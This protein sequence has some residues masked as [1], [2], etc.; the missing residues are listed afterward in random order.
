MDIIVERYFKTFIEEQRLTGGLNTANFEK[1]T[2]YI[3]LASKNIQNFDLLSS[4]VGDGSDAGIDGIAIAINNRYVNNSAE[5]E[6]ILNNHM[7]YCVELF[8][9]QA[10]TSESFSTKEIGIFGDGVADVLRPE[11]EIKKVM[12]DSVQEKYKM[13]QLI[14]D[15][16]MY[17]KKM[18]LSL[19]YV[20]PGVYKEDDNL[21]SVQNRVLETI[22]GLDIVDKEDI[23]LWLLDKTF[24]RKQFE[25]TKIQNTATFELQNKIDIPY[26]NGVE[27]AFLAIM[28]VKEYLKIIVDENQRIRRGI[29]ELNVRDFA[30]SD[31]NRVNQDIIDTL[32]SDNR[33]SFG[34]LNNGIT[35][36][37]RSLSKGMGKYTIKN[38]YIV[39]G[40][41]TSN[42]LFENSNSLTDDM[43]VSLKIVI[44]QDDSLIDKIVKATNNQTEVQE[45]QLISMDEYQ[46]EL[47]SY[48]YSFDKYTKLYYERRDGQYRNRQDISV[49]QIVNP[50]AQMKSFA[51]VFLDLPHIASRFS[52]K[53]QDEVSKKIFIKEH[54]PLMY[55]TSSLLI[56]KLD[57]LFKENYIEQIYYKFKYHLATIIAHV[58]WGNEKMPQ[59]NAVAMDKYC[60]KLI[61]VLEKEELFKEVVNR[62]KEAVDKTVKNVKASEANKTLDIVNKMLLYAE[63]GW[64]DRDIAKAEYFLNLYNEYMY[65]FVT[66]ANNYGDLRFNIEKN[67]SYLKSFTSDKNFVMSVLPDDFIKTIDGMI[68]NNEHIDDRSHRINVSN[69][70][71]NEFDKVYESIKQKMQKVEMFRRTHT[72][73]SI[74]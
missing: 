1:F 41:Q 71:R 49:A 27:E 55:Y 31:D 32:N 17:V 8:F 21:L 36:V 11:T 29:F 9:V 38:F 56:Y 44:T 5:L 16:Y 6:V 10:K 24:I 64:D 62:A 33:N 47:E 3:C 54:R 13:I 58:V 15:N 26:I 74:Y 40:C 35:I 50:E 45:I 51:S 12:N 34:F 61:E 42:V 57:L 28:P 70:I 7:D 20:T 53:L 65:A 59:K 73:E 68:I 67:W 14:I 25:A 72:S 69:M 43:W 30:G 39:N 2:N 37:G 23:K 46:K 22:R 66:I 63:T 19:Y 48:Y 52:G 4:C 60:E 18:T